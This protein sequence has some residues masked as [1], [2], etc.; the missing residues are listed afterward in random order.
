MKRMAVVLLIILLNKTVGAQE[1][2]NIVAHHSPIT[3]VMVN[4]EPMVAA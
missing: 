2:P 4:S 3:S 1:T